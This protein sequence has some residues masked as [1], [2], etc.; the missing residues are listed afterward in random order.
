MTA[1]TD[2][3]SSAGARGEFVWYA[4]VIGRRRRVKWDAGVYF[5]AQSGAS[6]SLQTIWC[7]PAVRKVYAGAT[8]FAVTGPASTG[9]GL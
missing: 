4:A 3:L 1:D 9:E 8:P 6:C 7:C 5:Q 2:L